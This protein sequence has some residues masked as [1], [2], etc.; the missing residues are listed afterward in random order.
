MATQ[1]ALDYSEPTK[2]HWQSY[3][4]WLEQYFIANDVQTG[5]NEW[6]ILLKCVQ[7]TDL[8]INLQLGGSKE[9][10]WVHFQGFHRHGTRPL[11]TETR[12]QSLSDSCSIHRCR[13][14]EKHLLILWWNYG[15]W[16]NIDFRAALNNM[17]RD[18]IICGIRDASLQHWLLAGPEHTFRSLICARWQKQ[19]RRMHRKCKQYSKVRQE[20]VMMKE[21]GASKEHLT[22]KACLP[23]Q[24]YNSPRKSQSLQKS[25]L[26]PVQ[27]EGPHH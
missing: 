23:L 10:D 21:E 27:Q 16:W 4:K 25:Y 14:T 6:A 20:P 19:Q 8:S 5:E 3:T 11:P 15:D 26:S 7:G 2:E 13:R 18:R 22:P 1:A 12:Q 17:L 24:W 9:T